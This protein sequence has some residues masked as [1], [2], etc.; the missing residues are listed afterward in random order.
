MRAI[1]LEKKAG[2]AASGGQ[3]VPGDPPLSHTGFSDISTVVLKKTQVLCLLWSAPRRPCLEW[4]FLL[5]IVD[6][7]YA[8]EDIEEALL[9]QLKASKETSIAVKK[10]E[11]K[12]IRFTNYGNTVWT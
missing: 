4:L 2:Q 1:H 7:R 9:K 6:T 10:P 5:F 12:N 3:V 8:V 11:E